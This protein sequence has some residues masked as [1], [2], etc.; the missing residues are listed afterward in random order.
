MVAEGLS[1]VWRTSWRSEK[2]LPR[3]QEQLGQGNVT[4]FGTSAGLRELRAL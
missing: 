3:V 2:G 1:C 4:A